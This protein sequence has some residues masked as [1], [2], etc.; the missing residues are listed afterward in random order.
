MMVLPDEITGTPPMTVKL[1]AARGCPSVKDSSCLIWELF[2]LS[3]RN[4]TPSR[5]RYP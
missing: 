1:S 3:N 5:G 4:T 2:G